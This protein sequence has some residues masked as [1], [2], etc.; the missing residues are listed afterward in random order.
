MSSRIECFSIKGN[1]NIK[2]RKEI[3]ENFKNNKIPLLITYGTGSF[4]LN[5]QFC[6]EI[7]Y[8]SINFDYSKIEQSKYRIKRIGQ[9]KDIKYTYF[10]TNLGI[11]HLIIEKIDT[12]D[13]KWL[14][15][16]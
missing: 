16:I 5:L 7:V 14:K 3:I 13:N 11:T 10:L 1:I 6:N 9:N 8:S 2:N 15:D 4:A 12:A